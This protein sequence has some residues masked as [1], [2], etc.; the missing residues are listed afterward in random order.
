M[1][2]IINL[3]DGT[4]KESIMDKN[5]TID[6]TKR[7]IIK[8]GNGYFELSYDGSKEDFTEQGSTRFLVE[9]RC[10]E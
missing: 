5:I 10:C 4:R 9:K 2:S 7:Q 6:L 8:T 1:G 3:E